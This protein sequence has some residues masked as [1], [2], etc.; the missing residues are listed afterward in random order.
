MKLVITAVAVIFIAL[1]ARAE[2]ARDTRIAA[3]FPP[4]IKLALY[5]RMRDNLAALQTIQQALAA[6]DFA[7][8]A[9]T[10]EMRLGISSL[11]PHNARQQPFMPEPMQHLGM[12][13]HRAATEF[14]TVAQE[15]DMQAALAALAKMT[16][17]CVACHASYRAQ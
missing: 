6:N 1:T 2:P 8:A 13:M 17:L 9:D 5:A 10:A 11:G 14:A 3:V 16:A 7:A 12:T 4:Q 15:R